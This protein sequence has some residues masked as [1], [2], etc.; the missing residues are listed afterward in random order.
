M[1]PVVLSL[2]L[3]AAP[4]LHITRLRPAAF[5]E[6]PPELRT[7]LE[8]RGCTIPQPWGEKGRH[9]VIKGEFAQPG[10]TDW[11]V[12]CSVKEVSS[13]L[14]FWNGAAEKPAVLAT[15]PDRYSVQGVG[16][17]QEGYSR[18][19]GVATPP[20]I[21]RYFR[22]SGGPKPPPLSHQGIEDNF[23]GKASTIWYFHQ[24]KWLRL[25]GAD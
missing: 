6:L 4:S 13:I 20:A 12:L 2:L 7:E 22:L 19:L 8:R 11:T 17:E 15:A 24:G 23:I 25:T 10:Q 21:R 14:V 16:D 1:L 3:F 9:N 5:P 18:G